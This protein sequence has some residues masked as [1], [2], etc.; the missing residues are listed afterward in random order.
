MKTRTLLTVSITL[1]ALVFIASSQTSPPVSH[2]ASE[3][4]AGEFAAGDYSFPA[5]SKVGVGTASPAADS[6]L[7]VEGSIAL[8][9]QDK[10][11]ND[12]NQ[13]QYL[14]LERG[15]GYGEWQGY[16]GVI[17]S[18]YHGGSYQETM[19]THQGK[20]FVGRSPAD[21][22][23]S[24]ERTLNVNNAL[25]INSG[26]FG[27]LFIEKKDSPM[28]WEFTT[29]NTAPQVRFVTSGT[30]PFSFNNPVGIGTTNPG[31]WLTIKIPSDNEEVMLKLVREGFEGN[32]LF[33]VYGLGNL[34]AGATQITQKLGHQ[35]EA[36]TVT[37]AD[38]RWP[39]AVLKGASGQTEDILVVEDHGSTDFLTVQGDGETYLRGN[40]GVG[41]TS[42]G[43]K[44]EV[45]G[46]IKASGDFI[47][48]EVRAISGDF[49]IRTTED[50]GNIA[51]FGNT[52][53]RLWVRPRFE[54][55]A[56][57][58]NNE[59]IQWSNAAGTTNINAVKVNDQDALEF[60]HGKV[61]V[62]YDGG[63]ELNSLQPASGAG[64]YLC[65]DINDNV[66]RSDSA[67]A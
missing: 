58:P 9:L 7:H 32:Q 60:M 62:A 36:L 46:N 17:L 5:G 3:V 31:A 44:L 22:I 27:A 53:V 13:Q 19:R 16:N 29:D 64:D 10:I 28:R 45:D 6:V 49:K 57:L 24:Q 11:F 51:E 43:E 40:V 54:A 67:C 66:Y 23:D 1:T 65:I 33:T 21:Y 4:A 56:L 8:N 37:S 18:D 61:V 50:T 38:Y 25:S 59:L 47:G 35:T 55:G 39:A 52:Q 14:R 30:A 26:N 34:Y 42:P 48:N 20:V 12:D 41:T 15:D 2:P 63:L